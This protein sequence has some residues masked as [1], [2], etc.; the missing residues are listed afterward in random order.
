MAAQLQDT[1]LVMPD[2]PKLRMGRLARVRAELAKRDYAAAVLY[3]PVNIRYASGSSNMQ[4]WTLHNAVRYLFV[5]VS[6]PVVLFDFHNCEHLSAHLETV[7]E[8][9]PATA[10]YY[11]GSGY[12]TAEHARVWAQELDGLLRTHGSGNRRVAFDKCDPAGFRELTALGVEITDGQEVMEQAR[13]IKSAEEIRAMRIS[14]AACEAGLARMRAALRPG[15][16]ENELWSHLHAENIARGGEWIETRLLASGPNTNPW[17]QECGTRIIQDGDIVSFDTD[18]IGPYG[19]CTDMS[20]TWVA[21]ERMPGPEQRDLYA[22][23]RE[24][25]EHNTQLLKPGVSFQEL[26]QAAWRL[27]DDCAPNR[28]SV[29]YH[30]VGL[31]DEYPSIY[32]PEDHAAVGYDGELHEGMTICVESYMGRVG[33]NEGVKLE[34]QVLITREGHELLTHYPLEDQWLR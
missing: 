14:I 30:G 7:D 10:W 24:Q 21:G 4:V 3:D 1:A 17:F 5:P 25:I 18:L 20:R 22:L 13:A 12:R 6:G 32:Y 9:R 33:G 8:V 31:C 19:Y 23:A 11:F 27:P 26:S 34:Q 15:I 29:V 2:M 16:S 28:Y